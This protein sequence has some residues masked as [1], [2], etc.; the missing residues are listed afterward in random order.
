MAPVEPFHR[1][2]KRAR[3]HADLKQAELARRLGLKPQAIQYLESATHTAQGSRHTAAIA[4]EC[5]VVATGKG[6]M[7]LSKGQMAAQD[8]ATYEVLPP[9]AREVAKAWMKLSPAN[10]EVFRSMVF[11]HAAIDQRYPWMR[12][13]RPRSETYDQFEQRV[14]RNLKDLVKAANDRE[15]EE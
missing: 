6:T 7:L 1:R 11:V 8:R 3:E 4:R 9:E 15:R 10:Q 13:G 5:G 14:A 2:L 12:R